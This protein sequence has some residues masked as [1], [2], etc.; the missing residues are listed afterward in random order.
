MHTVAMLCCWPQATFKLGLSYLPLASMGLSA[1]EKW[2]EQLNPSLLHPPL[3]AV[4]PYLDEY[5]KT[6]ANS[7]LINRII[8][9]VYSYVYS[10]FIFNLT[11]AYSL[12]LFTPG[13]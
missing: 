10:Y 8:N 7:E 12:A 9:I 1:L 13:L 11:S 2:V 3:K 4:L 5:L 6:N